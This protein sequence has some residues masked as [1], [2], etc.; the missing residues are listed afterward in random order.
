MG[1][2]R[3]RVF[4]QAL[5]EIA[6]IVI[7]G[8]NPEEILEKSNRILG[9]TL[10]V[11][12]TLIYHISF[13][14]NRITGLCE[15]LQKDLPE[16]APTKGEYT[17]LDMF[18]DAFREI[19]TTKQYL[20]SHINNV[21]KHF[22]ANGAD[23]ILHTQL[24]IKSLI[25]YPFA[26]DEHGYYLFT[27]NQI[28]E[29]R[30]WT[31]AEISFLESAAKQISL[32]LIKIKLLEERKKAEDALRT[33]EGRL[34]ALVQ[35][36][37][38][39]IWLKDKEG[40]YLSCNTM[41][42]RFFGARESDI[43]GKTDYDF[44]DREL[45]DFFREHD[46]I[47]IDAG[48]P[49]TNEEWITFADD[50]RR[51][52]LE[53]I[54][55]PMY[56][57]RGELIGVLGIGRDITTRKFAEQAL[58]ESE[59]KYRTVA[60]FTYDWE[61][62]CAPDLSFQYVSPSCKRI[63]GHTAEEFMADRNLMIQITHPEDR[64]K[65]E[66]HYRTDHRRNQKDNVEFDFR[67]VKPDGGISWISHSCSAVH[68]EEGIWLG[69]RESNREI[70]DRKRAEEKIKQLLENKELI[71]KEVHHRIKNNMYSIS[72]LL[73]MHAGAAKEPEAVKAIQDAVSRVQS[74]MVL[75]EK[76]YK[77]VEYN[78]ASVRDYLPALVNDIVGIFVHSG[79]VEVVNEVDDFIL[80]A[81]KLQTLGIIIN[82]LITNTM[83]YAFAG[84]D[85]GTIRI[86]ASLNN[87]IVSVT[88][89]DNGIGLPESVSFEHSTGFGFM[90]VG[91]LMEQLNG[92]ISIEREQGTTITFSF[93][94]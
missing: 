51:A 75:Y 41:F 85:Y 7:S 76:L 2:D 54:K 22:L 94:K 70:T 20:E 4:T 78:E 21:N 49:I 90:L 39:L 18:S 86:G 6:E 89:Q 68:N 91:F 11:D 58:R 13:E 34:H 55:T 14:E 64:P 16:I 52:M 63:T 10:N 77:S 62:W 50:G 36:I 47:A 80:D 66:E 79:S 30:R 8:E 59:E 29:Q 43:V 19:R 44:V 71:L 81:K 25:W 93:R 87:D 26:F 72:R 9:R 33:S 5:H 17:S 1:R 12:R 73:A 42:E 60:D 38:D 88:V 69:R 24:N 3:Q 46:R 45:A 31:V 53:T 15:W 84:R 83:K 27:M 74:V 67:I 40:R 65:L 57:D 23:T 37:P 92:T 32:A 82:E 61:A 35:T 48:K 28:M 56:D